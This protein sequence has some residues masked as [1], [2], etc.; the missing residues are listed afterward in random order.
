V[1][2]WNDVF[3]ER[4]VSSSRP[5]I[6]TEAF[7]WTGDELARRAGGAAA[8]LDELGFARGAA[9]PMIVDETAD[10]IALTVGATL[11]GRIPAPLGT[12]MPAADLAHA[13]KGLGA[14]VV[15]ADERVA[16]LA[17]SAAELAGVRSVV[18][19]PIAEGALPTDAADPDDVVVIIHTSGTTGAPKA[20]TASHRALLARVERYTVALPIGEGDRY[21]SASSFAHTA[22]VSMI[23]TVLALG[24]A[25]IPQDWFSVENWRR[26]GRLG[27]SC[28]LLVPTM[29]DMLIDAGAL[30]DANPR[31]LQYGASPIHPETLATALE[32]LPDT[33]FAQIFGQ[34]EVSP[35]TSLTHDDHMK[36]RAGRLDLL[37]TVGRAVPGN[38]L[39]VENADADGVGEL[40]IR[41]PHTFVHDAD[42]WRRTGDFGRIDAEGYVT[43][44]GRVNDRII[45]GGENIYPV[46]IEQALALHPDVHEVAVVGVPDRRWGE[47]VKAVVVLVAV[48]GDTDRPPSVEEL[49]RFVRDRIAHFKVPAIIEFRDELPRN[50]N[51]KVLRRHLL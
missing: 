32:L 40:A 3:R 50:P 36:A 45:R 1:T 12:K 38:E 13:I 22:G 17:A 33:R 43:L 9:V 20:I 51:G 28:A 10:A 6:V 39:R 5:A 49:Q 26:A 7:V 25:I 8:W 31:Y 37:G 2:T 41:S 18:L 46:E 34:T 4:W 48:S 24:A 23:Y 19:R 11:S 29:I 44:H 35:I 16:A 15:I 27:M 42:G 47:I 14:H 21:C 30:S